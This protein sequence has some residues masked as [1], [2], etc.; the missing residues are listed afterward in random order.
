MLTSNNCME[1]LLYN[2]SAEAYM[3]SNTVNQ[4]ITRQLLVA[5]WGEPEVQQ[6][7]HCITQTV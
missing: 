4:W 5:L 2:R 1:A 6:L 7:V 3:A